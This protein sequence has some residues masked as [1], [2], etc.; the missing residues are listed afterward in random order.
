MW[1]AHAVPN[2]RGLYR[3]LNQPVQG[4]IK[5]YEVAGPEPTLRSD[6]PVLDGEMRVNTLR[7]TTATVTLGSASGS[8]TLQSLD[9]RTFQLTNMQ[10]TR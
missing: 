2:G 1:L 4:A 9:A 8:A 5:V 3:R 6:P 10:L 7:L